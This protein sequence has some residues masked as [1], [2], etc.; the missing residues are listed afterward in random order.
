MPGKTLRELL[1]K[2]TPTFM[3]LYFQLPPGIFLALKN[4][5]DRYDSKMQHAMTSEPSLRK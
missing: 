4:G 3:H 5:K 1:H 2:V